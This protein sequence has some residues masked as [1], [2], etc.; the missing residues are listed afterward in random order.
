MDPTSTGMGL[1]SSDDSI[2]SATIMSNTKDMPPSLCYTPSNACDIAKF[3]H[4]GLVECW[5]VRSGRSLA[6]SDGAVMLEQKKE[7]SRTSSIL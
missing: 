6:S 1:D 7:Y 5:G 3:D 2:H 4:L